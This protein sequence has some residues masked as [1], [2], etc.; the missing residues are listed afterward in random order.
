MVGVS[1]LI[2]LAF[3]VGAAGISILLVHLIHRT[4]W[5]TD[6][7]VRTR[8]WLF[9]ETVPYSDIAHVHAVYQYGTTGTNDK[10]IGTDWTVFYW[11]HTGTPHMLTPAMLG[12][13]FMHPG[14]TA[15]RIVDRF[16]AKDME[17]LASDKEGDDFLRKCAALELGTMTLEHLEATPEF[18]L[19]KKL[20]S[21]LPLNQGSPSFPNWSTLQFA[22][23]FGGGMS[24]S[25]TPYAQWS[26][27][28]S[29]SLI[30][31]HEAIQHLHALS[32][33]FDDDE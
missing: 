10:G 9:T 20:V 19:A 7:G 29:A 30:P 13:R 12:K 33:D 2:A 4:S 26:F 31:K 18:V 16:S 28:G 25:K 32:G 15:E 5:L 6:S 11:T 21:K 14:S 23:P 17:L 8:F 1:S 22:G 3:I 24:G 27:T